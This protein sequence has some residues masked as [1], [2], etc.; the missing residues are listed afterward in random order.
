MSKLLRL[1]EDVWENIWHWNII[2]IGKSSLDH[3]YISLNHNDAYGYKLISEQMLSQKS[4]NCLEFH[5]LINLHFEENSME[6]VLM[7]DV[8][9]MVCGMGG[10]TE[11]QLAAEA[12]EITLYD[13]API[14][15]LDQPK[16]LEAILSL[17]KK[18]HI[19]ICR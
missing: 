12:P 9:F 17:E 8:P 7:L 13:S 5:I 10:P 3:N 1:S 4:L 2:P 15:Y 16:V 11:E 6:N 14:E 19:K 18:G